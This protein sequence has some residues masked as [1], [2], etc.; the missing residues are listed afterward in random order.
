ML[1]MTSS[2]GDCAARAA[3]HRGGLRAG[4]PAC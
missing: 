2:E 1:I 4:S 3:R